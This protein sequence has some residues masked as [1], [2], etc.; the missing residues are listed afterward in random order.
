MMMMMINYMAMND[1]GTFLHYIMTNL[2]N[3]TTKVMGGIVDRNIMQ[4]IR[5]THASVRIKPVLGIPTLD[6]H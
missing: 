1:K 6:H 2:F 5:T 3:N 4:N